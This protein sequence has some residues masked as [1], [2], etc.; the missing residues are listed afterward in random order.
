MKFLNA[1]VSRAPQLLAG[2]NWDQVLIAM[3]TWIHC[4]YETIMEN[5]IDQGNPSRLSRKVTSTFLVN[6]TFS[7]KI[8]NLMCF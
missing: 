3:A 7:D 5:P 8:I 1:V 4:A 6:E 2:P